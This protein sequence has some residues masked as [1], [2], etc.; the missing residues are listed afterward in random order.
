MVRDAPSA[1]TLEL[2]L[3][4]VLNIPSIADISAW[5][6][7]ALRAMRPMVRDGALRVARC[8]AITRR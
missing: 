4:D 5:M 2:R 3:A 6:D 8:R 1:A 7:A